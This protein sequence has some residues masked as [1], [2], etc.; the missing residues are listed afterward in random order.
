MLREREI[1]RGGGGGVKEEGER[2]RSLCFLLSHCSKKAPVLSCL[3]DLSLPVIRALRPF[4]MANGD[5]MVMGSFSTAGSIKEI[6]TSFK[7][8]FRISVSKLKSRCVSVPLFAFFFFFF[9]EGEGGL[10]VCF[11]Y[12]F[13]IKFV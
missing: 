3:V 4:S 9:V 6:V 1:E 11:R 5:S 10:G 12:Y 13:L 7:V 2:R 8:C